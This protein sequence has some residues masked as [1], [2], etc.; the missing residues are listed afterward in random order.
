MIDQ[1]IEVDTTKQIK[2]KLKWFGNPMN[3]IPSL[4]K[5]ILVGIRY[6]LTGCSVAI[7]GA[8]KKVIS[9]EDATVF[10]WWMGIA[11]IATGVLQLCVG[12]KPEK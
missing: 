10:V 2:G 12:I 5:N 6:G 3:P 4:L 11:I 7:S 1:K 9:A 8:P